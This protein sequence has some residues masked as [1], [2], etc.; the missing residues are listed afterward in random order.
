MLGSPIAHSRSPQL[1]LAAYA[2]LG[3]DWCY[4]R[5]EVG[6][7]ELEPFLDGLGAEW[8]GLSLTMPLKREVLPR[9][10]ARDDLVDV[11]GGAN[12]V[13]RDGDGR[14]IGA[15]T[16]V[17]GI[18]RAYEDHGVTRVAEG[19]VLGGGATAAAVLAAL[20]AM[21]AERVA[22]AV[23]EPARAAALHGVAEAVG[24]ELRLVR[25]DGPMP[26]APD[27]V[28]STLPGGT[29]VDLAALTPAR[30]AGA[31]LFDVAYA[32]WPSALAQHWAITGGT[33]AS[34]LEMLL[35]QAVGQ[36]RRFV[37]GGVPAPLPDEA[38]VVDAMRR[39]VGLE[40]GVVGG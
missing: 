11:V 37:G 15:N 5:V 22:V 14:W 34:G 2:A 23:R 28:V 36:V 32:P 10:A 6:S 25:L 27:T 35:H 13:V 3:L 16:D 26:G 4:E 31:V 17:E 20:G 38:G 29:P 1:H 40:P 9:L 8:L 39:A 30:D 7:G 33:V 21:G 18:V 24:L 19:L 12:T